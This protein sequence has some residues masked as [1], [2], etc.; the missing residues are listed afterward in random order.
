MLR[1]PSY[2]TKKVRYACLY[3]VLSST[4]QEKAVTELTQHVSETA[5]EVSEQDAGEM[6]LRRND[7]GATVNCW[8]GTRRKK[9]FS[10][11]KITFSKKGAHGKCNLAS[12]VWE[13]LW[14]FSRRLKI[15]YNTMCTLP[16]EPFFCLLEFGVHQ[17]L[18]MNQARSLL[19]IRCM[20]LGYSF[21]HRPNDRALGTC[22]LTNHRAIFTTRLPC[23]PRPFDRPR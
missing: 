2:D 4:D 21:E 6:T 22:W 7:R 15:C 13:L 16:A 14:K 9:T 18:C 1:S 8:F 3:L 19:S 20:L 5:S 10:N 23:E 17:R 11:N 12:G